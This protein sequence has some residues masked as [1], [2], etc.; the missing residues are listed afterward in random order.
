MI[1]LALLAVQTLFAVSYLATREIATAVDPWAWAWMRSAAASLILALLAMGRGP[2]GLRR[3]ESVRWAVLALLGVSC[4]QFFFIWGLAHTTPSHAGIANLAI[5]IHTYILACLFGREKA[6]WGGWIGVLLSA[7]GVA[8]LLLSGPSAGD[9]ATLG[10][11]LLVLTNALS[12]A[13]FL[14]LAR[15]HIPGRDAIRSTSLLSILGLAW[16]SLAAAPAAARQ[17]WTG[18]GGST[19]AWCGYAVVGGTVGAYLLNLWVLAR[20]PAS[21]VAVFICL[22]PMIVSLLSVGLGYEKAGAALAVS[23]SL[24]ITGVLVTTSCARVARA[25]PVRAAPVRAEPVQPPA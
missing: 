6:S 18:L 13:G 1:V 8:A 9:G 11:D 14:V 22:Q 24:T 7:G 4:N 19:W 12:Y 15:D 23:M 17:D 25:A 21:L 2:L 3:S 20:A 10:G 5:P 16:I